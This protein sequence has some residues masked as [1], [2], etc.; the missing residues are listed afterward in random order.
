[1]RFRGRSR[2]PGI[3]S[4]D[5]F[6]RIISLFFLTS[7]IF[8]VLFQ[9]SYRKSAFSCYGPFN[10]F[11]D[12]RDIR[13]RELC[14][15]AEST[16]A[17]L[18]SFDVTPILG[19]LFWMKLL[20]INQ[21]QWKRLFFRVFLKKISLKRSRTDSAKIVDWDVVLWDLPVSF[22]SLQPPLNETMEDGKPT[23]SEDD[24][25]TVVGDQVGY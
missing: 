3:T 11:R 19:V 16:V 20:F 21:Y 18:I 15:S 17:V 25:S 6:N 8:D 1:M 2:W 23:E 7:L 9:T 10:S 22:C 24:Q 12:S 5:V 13:P 14:E 4:L